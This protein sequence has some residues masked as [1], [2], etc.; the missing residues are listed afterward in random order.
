MT[1]VSNKALGFAVVQGAVTTW[2]IKALDGT[3]LQQMHRDWGYGLFVYRALGSGRHFNLLALACIC[4]TFVAMDGPLLQRA[5]SV[6]L[7][8]PQQSVTLGVAITPE[9]PAYFS[10]WS[11]YDI[12]PEIALD[13]T[14]EFIPIVHEHSDHAPITGITGCE[15]TCSAKVRAPGLQLW[16]CDSTIHHKNYSKPLSAEDEK[17]FKIGKVA[18]E[19]RAVFALGFG[20]VN[21]TTTEGLLF[22]STLSDESVTK[23]CVGNQ[24]VTVCYLLSAIAEYDVVIT[25]GTISFPEPPSYPKIIEWA[26]NTA[27]NNET[28][29][30]YGLRYDAGS[31]W[32]RST[33][34]GVAEIGAY[35]F[36]TTVGLAPSP[37]AGDTP[38][39]A[40]GGSQS[41]FA[42]KHI[43][44]FKAWDLSEQCAPAWKNPRDNVLAVLNEVMF[45]TGVYTAKHYNETYLKSRIDDGLEIHYNVT[46]TPLS[47]IEV[48]D[49]DFAYFAGA[50]AVELFCILAIL[51]TFSGFW[52]LGRH[53]SFSPLEI[54]KVCACCN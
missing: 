11:M 45:R 2:W 42:W 52:K 33:L 31:S 24:N 39:L 34:S 28:I 9:I 37:S 36:G 23:S 35:E 48:F 49:S 1:A 44:N 12:Y 26:N 43:T 10:G 16:N 14:T 4:G 3:T 25:N 5:S 41:W 53:M 15:G 27:I 54:A 22:S 50:A 51:F 29:A 19:D 38:I 40:L 32:I 30:Q 18:P 13:F 17:L 6:K 21:G 46:G 47:Q 7:E 20:S 8:V